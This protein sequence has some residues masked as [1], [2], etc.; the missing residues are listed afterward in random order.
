M[1]DDDDNDADDND[2]DCNY[3]DD[4]ESA[5]AAAPS[6]AWC[7]VV[8]ADRLMDSC[9]QCHLHLHPLPPPIIMGVSTPPSPCCT[10]ESS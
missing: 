3:D 7:F 4:E 1:F 10:L 6:F 9:W 5:F 2:D 8:S